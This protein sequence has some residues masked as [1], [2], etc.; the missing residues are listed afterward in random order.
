M[1]SFK[2]LLSWLFD[3]AMY[4]NIVALLPSPIKMLKEKTS[5]GVS[6]WTWMIFFVLQLAMS[7][8]GKLNIQSTSMFWGMAG[9][10]G[11]SLFMIILYVVYSKRQS[12]D[13]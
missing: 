9:S 13:S 1:E 6:V 7:L 8:H 3:I 12:D 4:L 10:A 11:V 5:K 2:E